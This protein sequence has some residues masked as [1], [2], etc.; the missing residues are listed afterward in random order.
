VIKSSDKSNLEKKRFIRARNS[1]RIE[2]IIVRKARPQKS[3]RSLS[4]T[5]RKLIEDRK[6]SQSESH[7]IPP[8]PTP[9]EALPPV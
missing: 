6:Y 7:Q 4:T 8:P 5:H 2:F 9:S 1:R 3:E